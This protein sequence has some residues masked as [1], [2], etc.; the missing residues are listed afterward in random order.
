MKDHF[1][2]HI[3]EPT[4]PYNGP[5]SLNYDEQGHGPGQGLENGNGQLMSDSLTDLYRADMQRMG[6]YA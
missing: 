6:I 4:F 2:T 5:F 1:K 3:G